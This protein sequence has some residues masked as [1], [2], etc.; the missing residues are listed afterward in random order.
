MTRPRFISIFRAR[1]ALA[2]SAVWCAGLW[3]LASACGPGVA[4][5]MPEPPTVFDLESVGQP[6]LLSVA[7]P[8]EPD[9]KVI[10]VFAGKL[11]AHTTV[12]VTN[13]DRSSPT[14][15][16]TVAA[17][18]AAADLYVGVADGEELRFEAVLDGARSAPAD[19]IFVADSADG[20]AF[21][22]DAAPRFECLRLEPGYALDF[23]AERGLLSLSNDCA[24]PLTLE[25]PRLR[26]GAPD[27]AL[28]TSLPLD[29]PA[30][31]SAA[32]SFNFTRS[33][34]GFREDILLFDVAL[35]GTTIRYPVTLRAE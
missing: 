18:G 27:F 10:R 26:G 20:R 24:S 25:N 22:L 6:E 15:A 5:P 23:A 12:R 11:P 35:D 29:V 7:Y 28:E 19:A 21:H 9:I 13:L 1:R 2:G 4:T 31:G 17:P 3:S 33:A 14:V 34:V 8:D 16:V 30:Q 32:L